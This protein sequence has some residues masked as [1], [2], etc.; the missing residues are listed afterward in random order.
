MPGEADPDAVLARRVRKLR[1]AAQV[2][3]KQLAAKMTGSGHQMYQTTI[4][5]I[6]AGERPVIIGE[7][8]ALALVLGVSLAELVTDPA[9]QGREHLELT[10]ARM[11]V[12]TLEIELGER[13]RALRED[14]ILLRDTA[15][16]L[17]AAMTELA[18]LAP[19]LAGELAVR[20]ALLA[21]QVAELAGKEDSF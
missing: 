21:E 4:A 7:A 5:K 3:Q 18:G 14:R 12:R 9:A 11:K 1:E 13:A 2:T 20:Q 17:D 8:V 19:G 16:R 6:E 15:A 10:E